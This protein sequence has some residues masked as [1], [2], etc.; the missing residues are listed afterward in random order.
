[1]PVSAESPV[2]VAGAGPVGLTA[3]LMLAHYGTPVR[4]IDSA[5]GPT[6]LSK[7]LVL[8]RRSLEV[9]DPVVPF[10]RFVEGHPAVDG[11][12]MQMADGQDI[13]LDVPITP[14]TIPPGT[15]IPQSTTERILLDALRDAGVTV[16]RGTRLAGVTGDRDGVTAVTEGPGG[17]SE[18]RTPWLLACD[19][20]HSTVRDL[21]GLDFPGEAHDHR[22]LLAD[23]DVDESDAGRR[24]ITI[25]PA[26]SGAVTLV[27]F[28]S[29]RWR[30]IADLGPHEPGANGGVTA[31]DVQ[32]VL[33]ERTAL[34]WDVTGAHWVGDLCVNEHRVRDY[35]H[36]RV[37]LLGDAA[38]VHGPAGGRGMNTGI[39]DAANAAWKI[40]LAHR[41][42]APA[43]LVAGYHDERHPAAAD[44]VSR[45]AQMLTAAAMGGRPSG[46]RGLHPEPLSLAP[47]QRVVMAWMPEQAAGYRDGPLD[48]GSGARQGT[49]SGDPF[50]NVPVMFEG[51][52]G[53]SCRIL[54]GPGATL[55]LLGRAAG[56]GG[57][58]EF[59]GPGGLPIAVRR[60]GA[61]ADVEDHTGALVEARGLDNGAVRVRPDGAG[62]SVGGQCP[63]HHP[64]D[65]HPPRGERLR[66]R[67]RPA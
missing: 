60:V 36:G 42:A 12:R 41:G 48:D 67:V 47:V 55:V 24:R 21:L 62:A 1:M 22:W 13:D 25:I 3:A 16:E 30:I 49:R 19:G 33:D 7:A 32:S 31:A 51:E 6:D 61:G 20:A 66:M 37:L 2:L 27:P 4:V 54:R 39:Q 29:S 58:D 15:L 5:D 23:V 45:S 50:P 26:E 56:A 57:P 46:R 44:V 63:P 53:P 18:T 34:G 8:W 14:H 65:H 64:L 10:S 35:V 43:G 59:G 40:A 9:L 11:I 38:H 28:G 52:E 17:A